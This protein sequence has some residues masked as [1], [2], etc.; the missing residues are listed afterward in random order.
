MIIIMRI[1]LCNS[2]VCFVKSDDVIWIIK[3]NWSNFNKNLEEIGSCCNVKRMVN[4][5]III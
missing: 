1:L 5:N 4:F 2:L 3:V